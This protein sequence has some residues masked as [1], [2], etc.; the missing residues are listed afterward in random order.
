M[1]NL[2]YNSY[3]HF[4][5]CSD[6]KLYIGNCLYWVPVGHVHTLVIHTMMMIEQYYDCVECIKFIPLHMHVSIHT[7][8]DALLKHSIARGWLQ[9][10][11]YV[12]E[13]NNYGM[14]TFAWD[15]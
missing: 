11:W 1:Y 2:N 10:A 4:I 9:K 15:A 3:S 7:Y 14:H 12:Y 5:L 13:C 8:I 6:S